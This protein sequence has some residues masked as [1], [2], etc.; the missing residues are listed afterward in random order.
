MTSW[1]EVALLFAR[2]ESALGSA[3]TGVESPPVRAMRVEA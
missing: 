3:A 1:E 2:A